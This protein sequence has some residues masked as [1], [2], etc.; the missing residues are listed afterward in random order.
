VQSQKRDDGDQQKMDSD[1]GSQE[2]KEKKSDEHFNNSELNECLNDS[3]KKPPQPEID[4]TSPKPEQHN[5]FEH[6]ESKP[7]K[8]QKLT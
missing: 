1:Y 6:E 4:F 3:V 7:F 8:S 2:D 5:N